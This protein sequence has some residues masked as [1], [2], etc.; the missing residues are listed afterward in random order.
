LNKRAILMFNRTKNSFL[1]ID[2]GLMAQVKTDETDLEFSILP[3]TTGKQLFEQTAT[4][5][6]LREVWFFGLQFQNS[7]G[8]SMWLDLEKPVCQQDSRLTFKLRAKLYPESVVD[9][10]HQDITLR[11]FYLQAKDQILKDYLFCPPDQS[12]LLAS[13]S[14]QVSEGNY[15][16]RENKQNVFEV[17]KFLC[18]RVISQFKLSAKDWEV[19]IHECWKDWEGMTKRE[20]MLE[21]LKV[22][23]ELDM[24]GVTYFDIFNKKGSELYLG[25]VNLGLNIYERTGQLCPR[26]G[27][28]WSEIR[29]I[30]FSGKKFTIKTVD[31]YVDN[32]VFYVRDVL[33]NQNIITLCMGN[34]ELY[35]RR[36]Q[37][38]TSEVT[39][40]KKQVQ[41]ERLKEQMEHLRLAKEH[42]ERETA[43]AKQR[44][45][46][47]KLAQANMI[48]QSKDNE[49]AQVQ[50]QLQD[51]ERQLAELGDAKE[52][53]RLKEHE[54]NYLNNQLQSERAMGEEERQ[55][56]INEITEREDQIF[57]M[58]NHIESATTKTTNL[59]RE[60]SRRSLTV[61][62]PI[63]ESELQ[64]EN[65]AVRREWNAAPVNSSSES[66]VENVVFRREWNA[67][68]VNSSWEPQDENVAIRREWNSAPVNSSSESSV[69]KI[70]RQF[71]QPIEK[72]NKPAD[73][74]RI[75]SITQRNLSSDSY[76]QKFGQRLPVAP[77]KVNT[78]I[79]K[80]SS[81]VQR[82]T[83][84]K[85]NTNLQT[86]QRQPKSLNRQWRGSVKE[87][88]KSISE[89]LEGV[90]DHEVTSEFDVLH[91]EN[92]RADRSRRQTFSLVQSVN[93]RT[94]LEEFEYL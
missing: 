26:I 76:V 59:Q 83:V 93:T 79:E 56:L 20:A 71:G 54:L 16:E 73:V 4:T 84:S 40:L 10:V 78:A 41:E 47:D 27:F 67:A 6:G 66:R 90:R 68:P 60:V 37:P 77:T 36:R 45:Y 94:R 1:P 34:H 92:R 14:L 52:E 35:L 58:K 43:E 53:L 22:C 7:N 33:I 9:E 44:E 29:D 13:Y 28:Q 88:L 31:K 87:K 42:E 46:E 18:Q 74:Q 91:E 62:H 19:K 17:E 80:K 21:Y 48:I 49:I 24:Y 72:C 81:D 70:A 61:L 23:Q 8:E 64:D 39:M 69:E 86:D 65:S 25:A 75:G 57:K 15:S 55:R 11:L 89:R 12:V 2:E 50:E 63:S 38:E 3:L 5:L 85:W 30:S 32:F 51:L 82:T